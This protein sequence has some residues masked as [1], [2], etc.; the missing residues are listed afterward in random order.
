MSQAAVQKALQLYIPY[1]SIYS[2]ACGEIML[3][4]AETILFISLKIKNVFF[5]VIGM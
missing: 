2:F 5:T 3:I 4:Y 1:E